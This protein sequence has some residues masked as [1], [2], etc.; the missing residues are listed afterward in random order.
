MHTPGPSSSSRPGAASLLHSARL[1]L[2]LGDA[3]SCCRTSV[4]RCRHLPRPSRRL[5]RR[6]P[7]GGSGLG[8]CWSGLSWSALVWSGGGAAAAAA[9]VVA[10]RLARTA[11]CEMSPGAEAEWERESRL[12]YVTPPHRRGGGGGEERGGAGEPMRA[13]GPLPLFTSPPL[14][15]LRPDKWSCWRARNFKERRGRKG[16]TRT[17]TSRHRRKVKTEEA[18]G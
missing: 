15:P 2:L 6:H 7:F 1:Q 14:M 18:R 11:G 3:P 13:R 9:A 4:R 5:S 17:P 12:L 16:V 10:G 8:A